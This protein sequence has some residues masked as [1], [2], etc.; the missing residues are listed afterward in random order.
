MTRADYYILPDSDPDSR[1]RFLG[2]ICEKALAHNH[3][4]Y[5]HLPDDSALERLDARL[6]S[7]RADAFVPHVILGKT[8]E[9]PVEIGF[10]EQR[11]GHRELFVNMAL[12]LPEDAF[13]FERIVEIVVQE[14]EILAA[15]RQNYQRC[16]ERGIELH[17]TDLR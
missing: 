5:I 7:F 8:P 4:V 17:R 12:D 3:R 2:R 11:P 14:A 13:E 10:G 15:T 16:R 6:W 9:A 1:E